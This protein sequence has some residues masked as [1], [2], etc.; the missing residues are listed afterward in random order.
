MVFRRLCLKNAAL[1]KTAFLRSFLIGV[2]RFELGNEGASN[3]V[4]KE[5]RASPAKILNQ[6]LNH[7]NSYAIISLPGNDT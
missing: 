5:V 3:A 2:T 1:K 6:N 7:H 4:R